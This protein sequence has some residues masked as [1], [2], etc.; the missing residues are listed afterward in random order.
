MSVVD[1]VKQK[2][3]I[4]EVVSQYVTLTKSGRNFKACCP[5]HEE[6]TPSF[7][8]FPERQSWHCF[9][10]CGTGGDVFS[11]VMK[12]QGMEFGEALRLLAQ[13]AGVTVPS[14]I[15]RDTRKDE[16]ERLYQVNEA[17]A[18]FFHE[19]LL[20]SPTAT[21]ARDYL[22]GRAFTADTVAAFQL[23]YSLDSYEALKGH[24]QERG[25]SERELVDAG[26]LVETDDGKTRDRF[27]NRLMF[28]IHDARGH[29]TGFGARALDDSLPKYTNSPQTLVFDKSGTLYAI[30]LATPTIRKQDRVIIVEG[31]MD[32][33][34]AHQNGFNNVV[35]SMGTAITERQVTTLKRLS[36]NI[37]LA[38]DAD[39]AGEEAMLR[40]VDFEN[41]LDAEIQV[42]LLPRGKDP[43]DVIR[44]E[45]QQWQ[46]L[47]E[48]AVPVVDFTFSTKTA[49]LDMTTA[50]DQS[51]AVHELAAIIARMK[52]VVRRDHYI[53]RLE[54]LTKTRYNIIEG[55][56]KEYMAPSRQGKS[57]R[58]PTTTRTTQLLPSNANP[59]EEYCLRLLLHHPELINM[60]EDLLP[61]YFQDSQNREIFIT[62][63]QTKDMPSFK[64]SL[65]PALWEQLDKIISMNFIDNKA[66]DRIADVILR[67][68]EQYFRN[69]KEER[70]AALAASAEAE[71][72]GTRLGEEDIEG[73]NRLL[74]VFKEKGR[75]RRSRK[76]WT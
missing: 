45:P 10:A 2:L 75:D 49:R 4:V 43:D 22:N 72:N 3:D 71:G 8:V 59:L 69:Q 47:V 35:A 5:F 32:T 50:R 57:K 62:L 9:G 52:D 70:A 68:Q 27:R 19:Q 21:R 41:I 74:E 64:D 67:L 30:D 33:I 16:R 65:D 1:E 18:R 44:D 17:A 25:F 54:I 12:Q 56:V 14:R 15:E 73:N 26:L 53:R 36:K 76:R 28:P 34:T 39:T 20:H 55:V 46:G 11:F 51:Q 48:D 37:I 66:E 40:C 63:L 42:I 60:S 58:E 24:L 6:R 61:E 38:L 29:T 13:Q 31:Y 23:G 7:F